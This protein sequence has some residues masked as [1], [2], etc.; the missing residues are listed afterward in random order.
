MGEIPYKYI[1]VVGASGSGT[2]TLGRALAARLGS[3]FFDADDFYW[4]PTVPPFSMKRSAAKRASMLKKG[5]TSA[6]EAVV[7]GSLC[8]WGR[9]IEDSFELVI[10]LA[11][12]T[13]L[14]LERIERRDIALYGRCEPKFLDWAARY[15]EGDITCRSLALHEAWLSDRQCRVIRLEGDET[16]EERVERA[17]ALANSGE[18]HARTAR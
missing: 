7:S 5:M 8:S 18:K 3:T 6:F 4:M 16:V 15:D 10:F 1:N 12:P 11:L 13:K 17:I 2:T 9:D 14:R